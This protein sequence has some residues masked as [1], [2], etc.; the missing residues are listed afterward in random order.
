MVTILKEEYAQFRG[1][2]VEAWNH[3]DQAVLSETVHSLKNLIGNFTSRGPFFI[4]E[5]MEADLD[6]SQLDTM[7]RHM[8]AL[9]AQVAV[10]IVDLERFLQERQSS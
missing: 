6:R 2:L 5:K 1:A 7:E 9:Q 10:L 8:E 4:L 3:R